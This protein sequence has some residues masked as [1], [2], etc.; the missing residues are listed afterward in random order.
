M[1]VQRTFATCTAVSLLALTTLAAPESDRVTAL[2][3]WDDPLPSRIY[4]GFLPVAALEPGEV[5]KMHYTFVEAEHSPATAPI[6]FWTNGGP[7]CSSMEGMMMEFGPFTFS[8]NEPSRLVRNPFT[9]NLVANILYLEQPVG[10]GFSHRSWSASA[11]HTKLIV[12][13][14]VAAE[15]SYQALRHFFSIYPE[16]QK[17]D[18]YISGESYAGIYVPMLAGR[19]VKGMEE[20]E[21]TIGNNLPVLHGVLV[22]NGCTG[23]SSVSCGRV[24]NGSFTSSGFGQDA[25]MAHYH[26]LISP[27]LYEEIQT[28]SDVAFDTNSQC[29]AVQHTW[30]E[31]CWYRD[32]KT[33]WAPTDTGVGKNCTCAGETCSDGSD[34]HF[35]CY[36]KQLACCTLSDKMDEVM[37]TINIY[38][39]YGECATGGTDATGKPHLLHRLRSPDSSS[40]KYGYSGCGLSDTPMETWLRRD[41]VRAAL[42]I[43]AEAPR[44][45]ECADPP[46]LNYKKTVQDVVPVFLTLLK[47]MRV[48]IFSGDV[49]A[50]VPWT[51]TYSWT[52]ALAAQQNWVPDI[53]WQPWT[54]DGQTAGYATTWNN[55]MA[56]TTVRDAGHM[57]PETQPERALSLFSRFV[58]PENYTRL[59]GLYRSA[60]AK[61]SASLSVAVSHTSVITVEAK[62]G[63]PPYIYRWYNGDKL[64]STLNSNTFE[65]EG[66]Y[67]SD[68]YICVV[69]DTLGSIAHTSSADTTAASKWS[70][71]LAGAQLTTSAGRKLIKHYLDDYSAG[72]LRCL[73]SS[74]GVPAPVN[75]AGLVSALTLFQMRHRVSQTIDMLGTSSPTSSP[76]TCKPVADIATEAGREIIKKYSGEYS[77]E[78]IKCV[79]RAAGIPPGPETALNARLAETMKLLDTAWYGN[80]ASV[81]GKVLELLGILVALALWV[82]TMMGCCFVWPRMMRCGERDSK[83]RLNEPIAL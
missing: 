69:S 14:E 33:G 45:L 76:G 23:Q 24:P 1:R 81:N 47:H 48:L 75:E 35:E 57:V 17:S 21:W 56:F 65:L 63:V 20:G 7:G 6:V 55:K 61:L 29:W 72:Q 5:H 42:H 73:L 60:P 39:I 9:W 44:W 36:Q 67:A 68:R 54:V 43:P 52:H 12:T 32:P 19:V 15:D 79:L 22:G 82:M 41:D 46:Q 27:K 78:D 80:S 11:N 30:S 38:N 49:D 83:M 34:C 31:G 51:G 62:G 37:G 70:C 53:S 3:G 77:N 10:V 59:A 66:P 64:L 4:S 71:D 13:D 50:A 2:P 8:K 16:Y 18:F 58:K 74:M 25:Q 40:M 26:T 28:C